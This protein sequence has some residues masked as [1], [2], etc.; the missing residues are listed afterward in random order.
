MA[1]EV[2]YFTLDVLSDTAFSER[3]GCVDTDSDR[4]GYLAMAEATIPKIL[5]FNNFSWIVDMVSWP[6]F[7]RFLPS[8]KDASGLGRL[9]G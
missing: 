5:V 9:M 2:Q 3:F 7:R 1:R 6:A 8:E 4:F